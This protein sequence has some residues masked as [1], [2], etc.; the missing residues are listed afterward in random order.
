MCCRQEDCEASSDVGGACRLCVG[1][2]EGYNLLPARSVQGSTSSPS[3]KTRW[4]LRRRFPNGLSC[5]GSADALASTKSTSSPDSYRIARVA[6]KNACCRYAS[7]SWSP[8]S[9]E[10]RQHTAILKPN[11]SKAAPHNERQFR[12]NHAWPRGSQTRNKPDTIP[13]RDIVCGRDSGVQ[14]TA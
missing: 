14:S 2:P 10:K 11:A 13:L 7:K 12:R 8:D 9:S 3:T 5:P 4:G 6:A 1:Q